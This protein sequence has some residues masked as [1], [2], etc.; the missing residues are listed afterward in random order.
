MKASDL[1]VKALENE[2][3]GY[4][5]TVP[6]EETLDLME[7]IRTSSIELIVLR[8]EQ[9]AGFMAATY[10]RLTGKPGVCLTTLGPGATN[11]MTAVAHAQLGGMP[12]VVITG[13]K[14]IKKQ[15]QGKFQVVDVVT[16]MR[17]LTKATSTIVHAR[18]IPALIRESFH[19]AQEETPGVVHIELPE[20]VA[21][22]K[23]Q[24]EEP[25]HVTQLLK[26]YPN[27]QAI[28]EAVK[29][30]GAA[31]HPLVMLGAGA[32]RV[33]LTKALAGFLRKVQMPFFTTQM[34]KG[35]VDESGELFLGTAALSEGDF[36]HCAIHHA[37]LILNIGHDIV[38]KPPFFMH[39]GGAKVIHVNTHPAQIDATYFP[40]LEVIGDMEHTLQQFTKKVRMGTRC[41]LSHY[42]KIKADIEKH[43]AQNASDDRFP[44]SPAR[45]VH[46]VQA[47]MPSDGILALD[48]GM[49]KVWFARNYRAHRPN[50]ILLDNALATMGAGLSVGMAAKMVYPDRKV[51]AICGDGGFMMSSNALE[52]AVTRQMDLVILVLK[53]NG[54][55]MIRWKQEAM[56]FPNFG[57]EFGNPDFVK[58][59]ESYGAFG[60]RVT[61]LESFSPIVKRCLQAGGVHLVEVPIDYTTN[62]YMLGEQ[63][64]AYTC[65]L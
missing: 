27:E 43:I 9:V 31:K 40:E 57:L 28:N 63:L 35:V 26:P 49:Y 19:I 18:K 32:N 10:G 25:L 58:Y 65:K 39:R 2:G 12:M 8:H 51:M 17:P 5:F 41:N 16:M 36:L 56:R 53:D 22:E 62:S 3:V 15:R 54:Y 59:A 38:E 30:I 6:G 11:I 34:G 45:L 60:E 33:D 50:T 52:T 7:S 61:T 37:D 14:P 23:C 1:L 24:G 21:R 44:I 48:N 55:G 13:Q 20:D 47:L 64:L 42:A 46:E 29:M 4:I